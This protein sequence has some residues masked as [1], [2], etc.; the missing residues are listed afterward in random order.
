MTP[1]EIALA[2]AASLPALAFSSPPANGDLAES[3]TSGESGDRDPNEVARDA[4]AAGEYDVAAE[5]FEQ[6]FDATGDP[7]YLFNIG[8]VY[9]EK[10]DLDR[11]VEYYELF[12]DQGGVTIEARKAAIDRVDVL[13]RILDRRAKPEDEATPLPPPMPPQQPDPVVEMTPVRQPD[14][15]KLERAR[16]LRIAGIVVAATGGAALVGGATLGGLA[17]RQDALLDDEEIALEDRRRRVDAV[18]TYALTT[19]ILLASGAAVSITGIALLAAGIVGKRREI[20]R[21]SLDASVTRRG[22]A[23]RGRF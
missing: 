2:L 21:V 22:I 9:E 1:L 8:R 7:S 5:A 4:F 14:P 20:N 13:E 6:A 23:V 15:A 16:R 18:E 11:A 17:L 3:P 10:G 12:L 19:D